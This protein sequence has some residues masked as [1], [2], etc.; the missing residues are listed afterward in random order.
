ML[1]FDKTKIFCYNIFRIIEKEK[2]YYGFNG[3]FINNM[4]YISN[5]YAW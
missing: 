2:F 1:K 3:N 5:F 4:V